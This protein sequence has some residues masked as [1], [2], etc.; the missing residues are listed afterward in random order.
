MV[1]TLERDRFSGQT[2]ASYAD[3]S[4]VTLRDNKHSIRG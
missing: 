2:L 4:G 3:K 1:E